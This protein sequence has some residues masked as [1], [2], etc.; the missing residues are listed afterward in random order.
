MEIIKL[1]FKQ[2]ENMIEITDKLKQYVVDNQIKDG[3]IALQVPERSVGLTI[4]DASNASIERDF[5]KKLNHLLPQYDG[6]QYTGPAT[7]GIKANMIGQSL[8]LMVQ[9]GTLILGL[10]QGVFAFDFNG[11]NQ[12]RQIFLTHFGSKLMKGEQAHVPTALQSFN[13]ELAAQEAKE[14]EDLDRVVEEM[15]KEYQEKQKKAA[16]QSQENRSK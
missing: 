15:R 14:K 3:L 10:H 2:R 8:Q 4:A 7:P 16:S 9:E 11:F 12:N 13:Q 5:L 6:M 1:H